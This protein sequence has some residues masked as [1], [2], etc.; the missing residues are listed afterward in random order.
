MDDQGIAVRF[1]REVRDFSVFQS[2]ETSYGLTEPCVWLVKGS[3]SLTVKG[4]GYV[5]DYLHASGVEVKNG[6]AIP[7]LLPNTLMA[8]TGATTFIIQC[9]HSGLYCVCCII[10]CMAFSCVI[11]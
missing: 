10:Y 3:L 2:V 1:L 11:C 7:L 4:P 6:P 5:A 9:S 8:C